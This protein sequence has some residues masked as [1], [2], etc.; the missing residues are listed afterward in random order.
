M[1]HEM[2]WRLVMTVEYYSSRMPLVYG[3]KILHAFNTECTGVGK[4]KQTLCGFTVRTQLTRSTLA[5]SPFMLVPFPAALPFHLS[6]ITIVF[7]SGFVV[8][9]ASAGL[10]FYLSSLLCLFCFICVLSPHETQTVQCRT[11]VAKSSNTFCSG[12]WCVA[13][14]PLFRDTPVPPFI[15]NPLLEVMLFYES[16]I[17]KMWTLLCYSVCAWLKW[18]CVSWEFIS[19]TIIM[20]LLCIFFWC[21]SCCCFVFGG[22]HHWTQCLL[23]ALKDTYNDDVVPGW[24]VGS[25][26]YDPFISLNHDNS[27]MTSSAV[28]LTQDWL[29]KSIALVHVP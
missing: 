13:A 9:V 5:S 8:V 6:S 25:T 29:I 27:V 7:S 28:G 14:N 3:K 2:S 11:M 16:F 19:G 1:A 10:T 21:I 23:A 18:M 12:S 15:C 20:S 26:K 17:L 24:M 4:P 22:C